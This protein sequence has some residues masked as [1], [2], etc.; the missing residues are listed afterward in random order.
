MATL[1]ELLASCPY[2]WL[3]GSLDRP[4]AG[5]SADSRK[6]EAGWAF[7]AIR[8][9]RLDGHQFIA[10]ALLQGASAVVV[11]HRLELTVPPDVACV[12]VD[13]SRRA[14][15]QMAAAFY[16]HPAR[17]LCLIGVTGTSGKTTSTY[18][19]EAMLRAP[20]TTP[21]VIGTVTYR[22]AG[23][24]Q[25]ADQTTPAA[26]D[27]QRLL[28]QMVDGGVSHC[29]M[30]V[31]SHALAQD[32]VWGCPF[33]AALFTNL[34]H[35]HL[36][37]HQDMAAYYAA[38]ARL[39]TEYQPGLAVINRD[40]PAG[41]KLLSE[42]R[43]PVLTYGFS[44]AADVS[45][46]HVAMDARGIAL[47]ARVPG[48]LVEL[49]SR[50]IGRHNVYNIL[51][52]LAT[53]SGLE[54]DL[55]R[56]IQGIESLAAV[57]G[58]FERVDVGQ[59]FSVVV[60]YAHKPDALRHMLI[61][62]RGIATG[63]LIVVFGAGGDRDRGKRPHMGQ[64]VAAYA[65]VAVITSDNPRS[66][67]PMD[68]IREVEAGYTAAG[69]A[70]AYR[71]IEDRRRAIYEAIAV[72]RAGDT[73]VIAG[74]GHETYQI[75]GTKRFPFDDRQVARQALHALGFRRSPANADR[76]GAAGAQVYPVS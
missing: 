50:L 46:D 32:R 26:E 14:L 75:I 18:L 47:R 35:D 61:A 39:F 28:R 22:Y 21:G 38:K 33:A 30:E 9:L 1:A 37:F 55:G 65:E 52:A 11:E 17:H 60:D 20:G 8:G 45:V 56:A 36:D 4:I 48:Q 64:L 24:E 70:A 68:I 44:G 49:R 19:L 66:E 5:V 29:V 74:K 43:A 2:E 76:P 12:R 58:R 53:A 6:V 7:V 25:P 73:V 72:A 59:P 27:L 23:R 16:G 3:Q 67:A 15:A 69:G 41:E 63:R 57:P 34:S 42:T 54:V 62:A 40:D 13:D 31:S 10:P 71:V 51:G